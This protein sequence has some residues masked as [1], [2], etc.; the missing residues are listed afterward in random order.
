MVWYGLPPGGAGQLEAYAPGEHDEV[1]PGEAGVPGPHR[2]QQGERRP[3]PPV[4]GPALLGGK[5]DPGAGAAALVVRG[6]VG[7]HAPPEQPHH[8]GGGSSL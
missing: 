1:G 5:A 8:L 4:G 6:A 3:Q 7:R 2:L